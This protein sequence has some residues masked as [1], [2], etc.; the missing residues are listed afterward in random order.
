MGTEQFARLLVENSFHEPVR[1]PEG[2][3]LA[4]TDKGETADLDVVA[5]LLCRLLCKPDTG[6]LWMRIGT[7][8]DVLGIELFAVAFA[9]DSFDAHHTFMARLVGKPWRPR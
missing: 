4:V 8:R 5:F 9:G 3:G 6:D 1:R 7:A 2:D